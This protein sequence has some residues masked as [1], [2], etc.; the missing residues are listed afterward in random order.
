MDWSKIFILGNSFANFS[1]SFCLWVASKLSFVFSRISGRSLDDTNDYYDFFGLGSFFNAFNDANLA[2][3][4]VG[5]TDFLLSLGGDI[6]GLF[7]YSSS[8]DFTL[9]F[10]SDLVGYYII[11]LL[12]IR[13]F[14]FLSD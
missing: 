13:S 14:L 11:E 7:Y 1:L 5:D 9:I 10:K 12:L 4:F 2:R 3:S 8:E 6:S